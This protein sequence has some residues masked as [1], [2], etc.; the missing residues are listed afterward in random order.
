MEF[1]FS[2][3]IGV[4][5]ERE[6]SSYETT[7][8]TPSGKRILIVWRYDEEFDAPEEGNVIEVVFVIT[9]Y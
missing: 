7:G 3:A 1:A 4:H 9:A 5:Q 6:D 2:H 8:T